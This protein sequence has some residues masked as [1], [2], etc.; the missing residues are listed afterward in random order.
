MI[1]DTQ[2]LFQAR[3]NIYFYSIC[4][5]GALLQQRA[6]GASFE[7][8]YKHVPENLTSWCG[9]SRWSRSWSRRFARAPSSRSEPPGRICGVLRQRPATAG[10]P[11]NVVTMDLIAPRTSVARVRF[12]QGDA[13]HIERALPGELGGHPVYRLLRAQQYVLSRSDPLQNATQ[14]RVISTARR[15]SQ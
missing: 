3:D 14:R 4:K 9:T 2:G 12:V 13:E 6:A 8:A 5:A 1:R 15:R 7:D 11:P 10:L